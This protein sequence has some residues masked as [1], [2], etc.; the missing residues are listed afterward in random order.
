MVKNYKDDIINNLKILYNYEQYN[1]N[2][3]KSRAYL[4]VIKNLETYYYSIN[5]LEDLK[6][7]DGIGDKIYNKIKELIEKGKIEEVEKIKI[8][9]NFN[10]GDILLNI[11][12]IGP[13]KA[14]ELIN[15]YNIK[16]LDDLNN[17][18]HLLNDKQL[19]GFKH[20][21]D[22]I[23]KIPALEVK[24]HKKKF[25][26]NLNKLYKDID[27]HTDFVGSYRRGNVFV[28]DIDILIMNNNSFNLK[29]FINYLISK[30]YVID[31]L[32]LGDNKFMG[33]VQLNP[34]FPARRM[35]ILVADSKK[36]YFALLYFTGP[37]KFNIELRKYVN[38]L[39]YSLSEYGLKK[40]S[41]NKYLENNFN[42]E[43]DILDFLKLPY[44]QPNLRFKYF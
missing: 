15:K 1:N 32:A 43:K 2:F 6:N 44:I 13:K 38:K 19:I 33:V 23:Q 8:E 12:G 37:Y 5:N 29:T 42:S 36:Y 16:S 40:L 35:D 9:T 18:K 41:D 22:L 25:I 27:I 21:K 20:Y 39:G 7:I 24:K 17:N 14:K 10:I 26:K 34:K 28:G 31:V 4:K 30:K 11:Y 3:F